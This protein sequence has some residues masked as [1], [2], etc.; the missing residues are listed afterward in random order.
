[1]ENGIAPDRWKRVEDLF[2]A[3]YSL[4]P[5]RRDQFLREQCAGDDTLRREVEDLLD[6]T[7]ESTQLLDKPAL[8]HMAEHLAGKTLFRRGSRLGH[9][10]VMGLIGAGGMGRVYSARDL[11]LNHTVAIKV[12]LPGHR[13]W[14]ERRERFMGEARAMISLNHPNICRF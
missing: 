11:N 5:K 14:H 3:A 9:F 10:D 7:L 8:E 4:D 13:N 6:H 12:L 1:M 2:A